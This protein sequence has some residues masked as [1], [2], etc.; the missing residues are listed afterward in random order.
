MAS[1]PD[2]RHATDNFTF[3]STLGHTFKKLASHEMYAPVLMR[4]LASISTDDDTLCKLRANEFAR[5]FEHVVGAESTN[6]IY[7]YKSTFE[8]CARVN[9]A[10]H[11]FSH[12]LNRSLASS[13]CTGTPWF[14]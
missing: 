6:R 5:A 13:S 10:Y 4:E 11:R 7:G 2:P 9:Q 12:E 14:K 3:C 1:P 8:D